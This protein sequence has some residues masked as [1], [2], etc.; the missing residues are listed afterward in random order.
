MH[1]P[2]DF[3]DIHSHRFY[4]H[5]LTLTSARV[6]DSAVYQCIATNEVGS[7]SSSA[8]L[9][10]SDFKP[11]FDEFTMPRKVFAV[12]G[13]RLVCFL[14]FVPSVHFT[15]CFVDSYLFTVM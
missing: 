8:R 6:E 9:T 11:R 13:T 12:P 15:R 3:I 4:N 2:F 14:L 7:A 10:V 5:R 1:F